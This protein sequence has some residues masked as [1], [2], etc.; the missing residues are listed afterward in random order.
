VDHIKDIVATQQGYARVT[1]LI[2]RVNVID[3]VEDALRMNEGALT[4]HDIRVERDFAPDRLEVQTEKHKVIQILVNLIRNAKHACDEAGRDDKRLS[5]RV[6]RGAGGVSVTV[7][8]NGVGIPPANL[9]RIFNHGF[10]TRQNGHGFGLHTA[11]LAAREL[12]G[13]LQA[14]SEGPGRGA[15]FILELP[16]DSITTDFEV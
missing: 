14:T 7:T 10:T 4:R 5:L 2:E 1:G 11:A 13:S 6:C 12:G 8:D 9:D 15:T 16:A 3:L